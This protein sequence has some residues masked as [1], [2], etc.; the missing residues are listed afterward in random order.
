MT[1]GALVTGT[2][3]STRQVHGQAVPQTQGDKR[4]LGAIVDV[5][6]QQDALNMEL[7]GRLGNAEAVRDLLVGVA[8]A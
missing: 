6:H 5:Q 4:G 1:G 2:V 7:Y 8:V 3:P